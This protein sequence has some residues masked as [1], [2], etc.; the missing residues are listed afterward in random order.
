MCEVQRDTRYLSWMSGWN[1]W[2]TGMNDI[3][4]PMNT[5]TLDLTH[6]IAHWM[7]QHTYAGVTWRSIVSGDTRCHSLHCTL[8]VMHEWVNRIHDMSCALSQETL[9]VIPSIAHSMSFM[10]ECL[11][12]M[13]CRVHCLK[14]PYMWH[15]VCIVS[16]DPRCQSFH[17]HTACH[18]WQSLIHSSHSI[19]LHTRCHPRW[20]DWNELVTGMDD[21]LCA[22]NKETLQVIHSIAH[23]IACIAH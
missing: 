13:T 8:D 16:R 12:Y 21:M 17:L 3:S 19:S 7:L 1:E 9:D 22:M 20:S 18:S 15:V 4:C 5:V 11:E 6:S 2:V 23:Y 14:R 10:N